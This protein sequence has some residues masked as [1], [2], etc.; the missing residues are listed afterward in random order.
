MASGVASRNIS[1]CIDYM[2]NIDETAQHV[3]GAVNDHTVRPNVDK[4]SRAQ[5]FERGLRHG[6]LAVFSQKAIYSVTFGQL[7]CI[8]QL[9]LG[10]LSTCKSSL[11]DS[12]VGLGYH[13]YLE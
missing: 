6:C 5:Q 8:W 11:W 3:T 10:A 4:Q 1:L 12:E 2:A 13:E 9:V 7:V